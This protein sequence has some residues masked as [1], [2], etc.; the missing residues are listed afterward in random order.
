M[1]GGGRIA[2]VPLARRH[3][4]RTRAWANDRDLMRLMD[5]VRQVG[6]AEHE[7]WLEALARRDD[8][9]YFAIELPPDGTHVGNVWLWN[10]DARHRKAELRI[11][12][13]DAAARGKGV[14]AEAIDALCRHA[15]DSLGLHRVYACVLAIN[16]RART[17]FERAR[18]RL[19]GTL[20]D[21]R[22]GDDGFVDAWLLARLSD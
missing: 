13:G 4:A 11:V 9:A 7:A 22:R 20:R 2:L 8:C 1:T 10:I 21:D 6:E 5:R 3:A 14:G 15:F 17:A 16:P 18:F 19:E 12:V